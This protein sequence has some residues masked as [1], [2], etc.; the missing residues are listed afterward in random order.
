MTIQ[1]SESYVTSHFSF[2]M[3][4]LIRMGMLMTVT[5]QEIHFNQSVLK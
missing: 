3:E 5:H 2:S 4:I 1:Y